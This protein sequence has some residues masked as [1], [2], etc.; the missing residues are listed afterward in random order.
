M[1]DDINNI[2]SISGEFRSESQLDA[3]NEHLYFSQVS[4]VNDIRYCIHRDELYR[5]GIASVAHGSTITMTIQNVPLENSTEDSTEKEK[6]FGSQWEIV[7]IQKL[8]AITQLKEPKTMVGRVLCN[9]SAFCSSD[10]KQYEHLLLGYYS[11]GA[12]LALPPI[13]GISLLLPVSARRLSNA[14]HYLLTPAIDIEVTVRAN[15]FKQKNFKQYKSLSLVCMQITKKDCIHPPEATI[16]TKCLLSPTEKDFN[17]KSHFLFQVETT[18]AGGPSEK[19]ELIYD[20]SRSDTLNLAS[21]P[22]MHG[23]TI[24]A[25]TEQVNGEYYVSQILNIRLEPETL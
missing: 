21:I 3:L 22:H 14:E 20:H 17:G 18:Y 19:T 11:G 24:T 23:A 16:T 25:L 2:Q 10:M 9:W 6:P 1:Q 7:E 13:D 4:S 5:W 15:N 8:T 12:L